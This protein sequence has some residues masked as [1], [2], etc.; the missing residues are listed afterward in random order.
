MEFKLMLISFLTNMLLSVIKIVTGVLGHSK[1]LIADG[2]HSF[3]DLLTDIVALIGVKISKLPPDKDHPWGH[4]KYEYVTSIFI[5]IIILILSVVICYES[6]VNPNKIPSLYVIGVVIF[7][8][9]VKYLVSQLL[10]VKSKKYNSAILLT[11]GIESKYDVVS[12]IF[13]LV[14]VSLTE[15]ER[16]IPIFKYADL[17]GGIFIS[18][19][20]FRVGII[21]L[22]KNLKSVIG[23]VE[24]NDEK[25]DAIKESLK[26]IKE[27]L[28]IK[29]ITLLKYGTYYLLTLDIILDKNKKLE[30]ISILEKDIKHKLKHLHYIK[31]VTIN[32]IPEEE[33][34]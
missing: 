9:I 21:L 4:G 22:I 14:F 5:S 10:I 11:S 27:I 29:K 18:I 3:S 16:F 17:I 19:L 2:M 12:S 23:E 28:K 1:T 33:K 26:D 15:L 34:N 20:I 24:Y 31:Y 30:D 13:A 32:P 6:I 7:V 25:E 8:I